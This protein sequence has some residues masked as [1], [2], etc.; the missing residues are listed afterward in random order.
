MLFR[1]TITLAA[2]C[3]A[4]AGAGAQQTS[5]APQHSTAKSTMSS[6]TSPQQAS[7]KQTGSQAQTASS[8]SAR[9]SADSAKA[10]ALASVPNATVSSEKLGHHNGRAA[11]MF[12]LKEQGQSSPVH[13]T[14]DA[15]TGQ[16]SHLKSHSKTH[17]QSTSATKKPSGQ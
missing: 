12:T 7:A 9:I 6:K 8:A 16:F 4:A 1:N 15:E 2:L 13:V 5:P 14:V 3:V 17:S 10:I 11:Y